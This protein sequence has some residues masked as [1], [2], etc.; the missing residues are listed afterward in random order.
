MRAILT[1][2]N[3]TKVRLFALCTALPFQQGFV[4]LMRRVRVVLI[5]LMHGYVVLFFL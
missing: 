4:F 5:A 2:E 3:K 1:I